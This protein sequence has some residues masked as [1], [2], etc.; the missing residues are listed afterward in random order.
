MVNNIDQEIEA[1]K[2]LI[3]VLEPLSPDVRK[4]VLDYAIKRLNVETSQA[5]TGEPPLGQ[6]EKPKNIKQFKEQKK[7]KSAVEMAV[8]IAYY[9][10]HLAPDSERKKEINTKDLEDYFKM[11]E[12]KKPSKIGFTLPNAKKAGY[13][14]SA[15]KGE[16]KLN[17][18]GYNL[19][20]HNMPRKDKVVT[21]RS[22]KGRGERQS[23][24]RQPLKGVKKRK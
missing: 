5:S 11:A 2:T 23:T 19:V 17:P 9:L 4:N 15:E 1:I 24:K 12:F 8:L 20:V 18:V 21:K 22:K 13:L 10:S 6:L 3:Q 16:Y 7:P 14:D